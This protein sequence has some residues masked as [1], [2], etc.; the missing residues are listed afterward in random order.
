MLEPGGKKKMQ[1]WGGKK[2]YKNRDEEYPFSWD[3]TRKKMRQWFLKQFLI[4]H[5]LLFPDLQVSFLT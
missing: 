5:V 3:A 4:N 2:I 1:N